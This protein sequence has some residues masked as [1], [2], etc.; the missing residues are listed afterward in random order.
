MSARQRRY[1][2]GA[3]ICFFQLRDLS[4]GAPF[5]VTVRQLAELVDEGFHMSLV[6]DFFVKHDAN[7]QVVEK[8][9]Q[10]TRRA[11]HKGNKLQGLQ[12]G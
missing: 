10:R 12:H 9:R 3:H 2:E 7:G 5:E 4:R 6:F 11:G 8:S 1:Y